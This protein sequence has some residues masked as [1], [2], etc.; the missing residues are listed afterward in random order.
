MIPYHNQTASTMLWDG[1]EKMIIKPAD[2]VKASIPMMNKLRLHLAESQEEHSKNIIELN[3]LEM[4]ALS[5][6]LMNEFNTHDEYYEVIDSLMK[7]IND[8]LAR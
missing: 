5:N 1:D 8:R 3:E 2:I 4:K 6:R 7:K